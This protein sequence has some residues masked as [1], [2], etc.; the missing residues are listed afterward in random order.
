[1]MYSE[2]NVHEHQ[3]NINNNSRDEHCTH[4]RSIAKVAVLH[5]SSQTRL[6]L[7][8]PQTRFS[9]ALFTARND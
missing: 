9:P 4:A 2:L 1:M 6:P 7:K 8:A 3:K 5:F